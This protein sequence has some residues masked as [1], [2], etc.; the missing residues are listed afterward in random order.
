MIIGV[1]HAALQEQWRQ[2]DM[3]RWDAA[4]Q[5]ALEKIQQDTASEFRL[6]A[7]PDLPLESVGGQQANLQRL[8]A[9]LTLTLTQPETA[10]RYGLGGMRAVLMHG[11]PR[12]RQDPA[13]ESGRRLICNEQWGALCHIMVVKP[14]GFE[15][16]FVGVTQAGKSASVSPPRARAEGF[17]LLLPRRDRIDRPALA[18]GRSTSTAIS[19]SPPLLVEL[20]RARQRRAALLRRHRRHQSA[21]H[22]RPEARWCH[23]WKYS[24]T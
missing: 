21:R 15:N 19:S 11:P 6:E 9:A 18:A 1:A 17:G 22:A 10:K 24:F 8:I 3:V 7:V 16:E 13:G 4:S 2:G 23:E 20:Q 14:G 12:H 5:L